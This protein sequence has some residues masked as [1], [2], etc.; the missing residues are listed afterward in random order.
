VG[1][2]QFEDLERCRT[3]PLQ[4][5]LYGY[6]GGNPVNF[7]DPT[8]TDWMDWVAGGVGA[9]VGAFD[10]VSFGLY[11]KAAFSERD[12]AVYNATMGHYH[13]GHVV[14]EVVTDT[15]LMAVGI[16][17][18]STAV[19]IGQVGV[20]IMVT[21]EGMEV[22][23]VGSSTIAAA[24]GAAKLVYGGASLAT[25][26]SDMGS[27]GCQC[28]TS[29]EQRA[30][31]IHSELDD[32]AASKR[33]T[34]VTE[35]A[36]GQ[37]VVSCSTNRLTP[38]QRAALKPGEVEG[39]GAGHAEKNQCERSKR[40]GAH[41]HRD[42]G[43]Q[44]NLPGMCWFSGWAGC[45][46][47]QSPPKVRHRSYMESSFSD[48]RAFEALSA[49]RSQQQL[50]FGAACCERMLPS[51]EIFKQESGWGNATPLREALDAIWVVCLG[52][53]ASVTQLRAQLEMCE[54]CAPD[55]ED[56]TVLHTSAAQDAAFSICSLIEFLLNDD[57]RKIVSAAR[58]ATDSVDLIVQ[59]QQNM[60]ARD[61]LREQKILEQP[62]MQQELQRQRRDL[63]E[64]GRILSD[65][66]AGMIAFRMRA[67]GEANLVLAT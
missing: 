28:S 32:I 16:G 60:D 43:K 67:Q 59:E 31:E 10:A 52:A 63:S 6:A 12:A 22:L 62:L 14:G 64:A 26:L 48:A 19:K 15:G 29:A 66:R 18:I 47:A 33:T 17:E 51:Y 55:S 45:L 3:S 56:F 27:G 41:A 46:P 40:D 11:S 9:M 21:A 25:S 54:K 49:M 39:V 58:F 65:D 44:T 13:T 2:S 37:R 36:E 53:P 8:G 57:V 61:P 34:A 23:S 20:R 38:A 24:K 5:S 1:S 7:V 42:R 30:K 4:C 35:T 50:A